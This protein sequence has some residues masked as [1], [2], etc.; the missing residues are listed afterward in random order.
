M[1][2]DK[3]TEYYEIKQKQLNE[4]GQVSDLLVINERH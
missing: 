3:F 1:P 2:Y 4:T